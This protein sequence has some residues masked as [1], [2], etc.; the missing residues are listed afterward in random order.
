VNLI[1]ATTDDVIS[2]M[3]EGESG[4]LAICPN[5]ERPRFNSNK[6]RLE[7]PNGAKSM[8][9]SAEEPERLRGK[10]HS[11][12][13]ADELASWRYSAAWD[14][15]QFGLR[16]GSK[17]QAIITTTPRPTQI[18]RDLVEDPLTHLTRGR[19]YDNIGNLAETFLN[20]VIK[21]YEGT[22]LGRQELEAHLLMDVPG[23]LWNRAIL[24]A[25]RVV[26]VPAFKR[27][28]VGLDPPATSGE[29]A[30]ECG[31]IV[32]GL[33]EDDHGYVLEDCSSQGET[34]NEWAK[35]AIAAYHR[36]EASCIVAEVN[37]GG[38]MI[39]TIMRAIDANIP[40]REV[41][42]SQG[43][44]TRA[45]PVS[46]LYAQGRV[47][48]QG[49]FATL[50]DQMCIM[51]PDFDRKA[52]KLSPDRVD[53]LVWAFKELM[54]KDADASAIIEH[55]RR[56]AASRTKP[57]ESNKSEIAIALIAPPQISTAYSITGKMYQVGANGR[58][59]V[60][61]EDVDGFVASGFRKENG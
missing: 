28:V 3:I 26:K 58:V 46:M 29:G 41:R 21:K 12:L 34:P 31:I 14:Q 43:K 56:E 49:S 37:N 51:T 13:W 25:A 10:Q 4:I 9:F 36:H 32:A 23:A 27:V 50:E 44:F 39:A 24:D 42:A 19:T 60:E 59:L 35:R 1:G 15:A 16:L 38:E 53:A 17:P 8:Y 48:H 22:R 6:R 18:M 52:M 33:G 47:H 7:W 61:P 55:Y 30:D 40:V 57:K 45:E 5:G 54:L 2:V 11:K 20:K